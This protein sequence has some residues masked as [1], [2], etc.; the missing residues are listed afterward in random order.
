MTARRDARS[1]LQ[2]EL[3]RSHPGCGVVAVKLN[4]P[5]PVKTS[6]VLDAVFAAGMS[7]IDRVLHRLDPLMA[8]GELWAG[9]TGPEAFRVVR[10]R[11]PAVKTTLVGFEEHDTCGRLFDADVWGAD[12]GGPDAPVRT[13]S[14]TELGLPSRTCVVCGSPVR[15]CARSRRHGLDALLDAIAGIVCTPASAEFA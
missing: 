8:P 12:G 11:L 4:I 10:S 15:A 7:R 1:A 2:R 14:R 13:M 5:G 9:P 6:P 3:C